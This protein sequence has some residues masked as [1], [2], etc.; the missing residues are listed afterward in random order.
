ME[1]DK[2]LLEQ[3]NMKTFLQLLDENGMHDEKLSVQLLAGYVDQ[4]EFQFNTVLEELKNVRQELNTIQDK[5][6][7]ATA[8]RAV[9]KVVNKVEEAKGQLMK[10][11]DHIITTVDKAVTE[12]KERGKSALVTAMKSLNVTGLL[13]NI[14]NGLNHA[15]Q[16]ADHGIDKLT[17]FGNEVHAVNSHLKN[18]GRVL[19]GKDSKDLEPRDA[20]KGALPKIQESLFF[21]MSAFSHMSQI[22]DVAINAV[23]KFEDKSNSKKSVKNEL[24]DIKNKQQNNKSNYKSG[25]EM[26]LGQR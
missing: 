24:Q 1:K 21:S 7:R 13:E 6:L 25:K 5:T 16:S 2:N 22:T 11:K 17:K 3:E 18:A 26:K 12:F 4:M 14:K 19:T 15:A 9:D 23:K 8:T 10:L 20:D